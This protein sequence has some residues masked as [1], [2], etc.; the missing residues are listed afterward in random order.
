[1]ASKKIS[2]LEQNCEK[3]LTAAAGLALAGVVVW[4][5][6]FVEVAVESG[7]SPQPLQQVATQIEKRTKALRT[8]LEGESTIEL[9]AQV[10]MVAVVDSFATEMSEPIS[11]ARSLPANQPPLAKSIALQGIR[12]DEWY[13]EPSL[14]TVT[15][16]GVVVTTDALTPDAL[17]DGTLSP[18]TVQ[19][20]PD[21]A[22]RYP[23]GAP[24]D[25]TWTTPWARID[26]Q[27]MRD[28]LR[29]KDSTVNPSR[30]QIPAPWFNDTLYVVDVVFERQQR[31]ADGAWG[32][33]TEVEPVPGVESWRT[34]IAP[35]KAN[36][37]TRETV[38]KNLSD[39][40]GQMEVLQPPF[41]STKN[42][43]FVAPGTESDPVGETAPAGESEA[44]KAKKKAKTRVA[45]RQRVVDRLRV[46][47]E[48][49][50]GP[51][52]PPTPGSGGAP[53]PGFGGTDGGSGGKKGG[54]GGGGGGLGGGG[55]FQG[56]NNP[57]GGDKANEEAEKAARIRLTKQLRSAERELEEEAAEFAKKYPAP[58]APDAKSASQPAPESVTFASMDS[59]VAWT[60]D[61]KV[62]AGST[63]RYRCVAEC[64]NPF[65]GR[66]TLL[67][68]GQQARADQFTISTA[69]SEW[70]PAVTVADPT[71]FFVLRASGADSSTSARHATIE[72]YRYIDG[73]VDRQVATCAPGDHVAKID[74]D[75]STPDL[76]QTSW[77]VVDIFDDVT[78]DAERGSRKSTVVVLE[79]AD[80]AGQVIREHRFVE[81]DSSSSERASLEAEFLDRTKSGG[82]PGKGDA[83]DSAGGTAGGGKPGG[84]SGPGLGS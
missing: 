84:P 18:D 56:R 75:A 42:G 35:G 47:L 81:R 17:S 60:H 4:Q 16:E 83:K 21:L 45:D 7:G 26:L 68:Q 13:Y 76:F 32:P 80:A 1:M 77:Y 69:A 63:Y 52:A 28:E 74:A 67:V 59:V 29:R 9:P 11:P 51:L 31:G 54:E 3:F 79:R 10:T 49:I 25:I 15:V 39:I 57:G 8:K 30:A 2:F 22:A 64:Y 61:W 5:L 36:A 66:K 12:A 82:A 6:V 44:D 53:G 38:F 20:W 43:K 41:L 40:E 78:R 55:G 46:Q 24:R 37:S 33:A 72:L 19:K 23:E 70:G 71:R 62:E 48:K 65:F 14:A 58:S 73:K 50:G 27:A 34:D